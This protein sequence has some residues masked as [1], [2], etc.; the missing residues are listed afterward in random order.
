MSEFCHP[1]RVHFQAIC[2]GG[3]SKTTTENYELIR[4]LVPI[5]ALLAFA[6][7]PRQAKQQ[8]FAHKGSTGNSLSFFRHKETDDWIFCCNSKGECGIQGDVT[9]LWFQMVWRSGFAPLQW[10]KS[11]AANDLLRRVRKGEIDLNLTE[12]ATTSRPRPPCALARPDDPY[13][14]ELKELVKRDR[15]S[16]GE[17]RLPKPLRLDAEEAILG[18]HPENRP[19]MLTAKH[20]YHPIMLRDKW[21]S[22]KGEYKV[23]AC[24]LVSSNYCSRLDADGTSYEAFE[25]IERRWMVI[26]DDTLTLEEQFWIH[27]KLAKRY[28]NLGLVCWSG[29]KSIHG[30][31]FIEGWT[32]QECFELYAKA[33]QLGIRDINQWRI[34]QQVRLPGG[35]N[36]KTK[37]RQRIYI[38]RC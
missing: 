29:G 28:E 33:V 27:T 8:C 13:W 16:L 22:G 35:Y 38:N 5:P 36:W 12:L 18:L 10:S 23:P 21:L 37:Q 3:F 11:R 2:E 6:G 19:I 9:E 4:R 17:R 25:G 20:N 7:L 30:W 14:E 24:S 1:K 32:P 31:Y 26:E 15:P 34:C